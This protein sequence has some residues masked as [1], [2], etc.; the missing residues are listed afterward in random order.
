V[1]GTRER[2]HHPEQEADPDDDLADA[3]HRQPPPF[4]Q[5]SID[6]AHEG[7]SIDSPART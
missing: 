6:P 7:A 2:E 5:R 1:Y 4:S 3:H